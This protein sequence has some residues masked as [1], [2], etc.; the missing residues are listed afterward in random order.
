MSDSSLTERVAQA[1]ELTDGGD[2]LQRHAA[3]QVCALLKEMNP[4]DLTSG[5]T[6]AIVT[7]LSH[8]HER[9]LN[10]PRPPISIVPRTERREHIVG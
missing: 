1:L 10:A 7:I 2:T 6:M 3:W 8:A 5:E 4:S 9:K